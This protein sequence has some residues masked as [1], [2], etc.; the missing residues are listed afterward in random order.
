M[1]SIVVTTSGVG[2]EAMTRWPVSA[3]LMA[4]SIVSGVG[5]LADHHDVRVLPE[6]GTHADRQVVGI[7]PDLPLGDRATQIPVQELDRILDRHDVLVL[8]PV[9]VVHHRR[10]GRALAAP[11][12]AGHQHESPLRLGDLRQRLGQPEGLD[13]GNGERDDPHDDHE[14]GALAE[15]VDPETADA[16]HAPG[17]V[18]VP[19]AV[20]LGRDPRRC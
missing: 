12:H 15:H 11:A 10:H 3:P 1:R 14:G 8:G 9:D 2:I 18:E 17:T 16:G 4:V 6:R 7:D 20:D 5:D 13:G 19:Q